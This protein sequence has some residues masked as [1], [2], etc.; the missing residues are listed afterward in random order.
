MCDMKIPIS[1]LFY[2]S[3]LEYEQYFKYFKQIQF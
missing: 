2:I 3:T 1:N